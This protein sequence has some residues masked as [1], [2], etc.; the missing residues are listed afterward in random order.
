LLPNGFQQQSWKSAIPS[1]YPQAGAAALTR[2]RLNEIPTSFAL[3][4]EQ[5]D[6]LITTG[7]E[8]LRNNV[9]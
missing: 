4:D 6:R 7:R 5:A 1:R 8:L 3:D 2:H 9:D